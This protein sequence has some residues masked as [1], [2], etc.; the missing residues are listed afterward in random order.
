[1]R[2]PSTLAPRPSTPMKAMLT[3]KFG[4]FAGLAALALI[5]VAA[6]YLPSSCQLKPEQQARLNAIAVPASSILSKV[7]IKEGWIEPGDEVV[8]QRGVAVVTSAESRDV[9]LFQ[10]AELGLDAALKDGLLNEGDTVKLTTPTE[11]TILTPPFQEP[12]P[13]PPCDFI[14]APS[15]PPPDGPL[16]P[17]LP[18]ASK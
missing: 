4:T 13:L 14:D 11:A 17:L 18:P 6:A 7:A 12:L 5:L 8:I 9:K 1:M 16:N 3:R 10:L 15:A 2:R